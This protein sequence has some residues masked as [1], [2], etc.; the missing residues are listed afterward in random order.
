MS[1]HGMN[2]PIVESGA[3]F[4]SGGQGNTPGTVVEQPPGQGLGVGKIPGYGKKMKKKRK[5]NPGS[6]SY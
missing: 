2:S 1:Q 5:G 3:P 6:H 4:T